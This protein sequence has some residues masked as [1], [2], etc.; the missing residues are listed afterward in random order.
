MKNRKLLGIVLAG[1]GMIDV[2]ISTVVLEAIPR[3]VVLIS[4]LATIAA[5]LFLFIAAL[6]SGRS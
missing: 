6:R 5:G 1:A 3:T 2:V 4:G